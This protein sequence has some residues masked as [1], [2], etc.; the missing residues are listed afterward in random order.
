MPSAP[1][2]T[3]DGWHGLGWRS[4]FNPATPTGTRV[5]LVIWGASLLVV[6]LVNLA[7]SWPDRRDWWRRAR[8]LRIRGLL[9]TASVLVLAPP[10]LVPEVL[11]GAGQECSFDI[12]LLAFGLALIR[13]RP[14]LAW[15]F[16]LWPIVGLATSLGSKWC[17]RWHQRQ[18][19]PPP[20]P[21]RRCSCIAVPPPSFS[22]DQGT[23]AFAHLAGA[24][25][26][27]LAPNLV[28]PSP[29]GFSHPRASCP[30][31]SGRRPPPD[32]V[33]QKARV[34]QARSR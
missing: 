23:A 22:P 4:I 2:P 19:R 27:G 13:A 33:S 3:F 32:W 6:I 1:G 14:I 20:A 16:R 11:V 26:S 10:V 8:E 30:R 21:A 28:G 9:A 25:L 7:W 29:P 34:R 12:G 24:C 15:R 5:A 18:R 31:T 17:T